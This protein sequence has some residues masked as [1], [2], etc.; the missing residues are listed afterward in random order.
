MGDR[1][2]FFLEDLG[3]YCLRGRTKFSEE[4][5]SV[6]AAV[7]NFSLAAA[8][9]FALNLFGPCDSQVRLFS[10][11]SVAVEFCIKEE[12]LKAAANY[13]KSCKY[14]GP[15]EIAMDATAVTA[16]VRMD[17]KQRIPIGFVEGVEGQGPVTTGQDLYN[18]FF[19][20]DQPAKRA[21]QGMLILLQ[22]LQEG[23]PAYPVGIIPVSGKEN[24]DHISRWYETTCEFALNSGLRVIGLGADGCSLVR[25]YYSTKCLTTDLM[26]I[27]PDSYVLTGGAF[28]HTIH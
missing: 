10:K 25:S 9:T 3:K 18:G 4:T 20:N 6:F 7:F 15:F 14:K 13:Y 2:V 21:T 1:P 28:K 11:R 24:R 19:P 23:I 12:T 8:R 16:V 5:L 22:P 27:P 17:L 26:C